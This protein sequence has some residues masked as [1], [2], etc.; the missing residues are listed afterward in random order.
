LAS[1]ARLAQPRRGAQIASKGD[2][3]VVIHRQRQLQLAR[4]QRLQNSFSTTASIRAPPT[5]QRL[6]LARTP[7]DGRSLICQVW[8]LSMI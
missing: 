3:V 6:S 7:P 2:R 4:H 8:R 1:P 5:V